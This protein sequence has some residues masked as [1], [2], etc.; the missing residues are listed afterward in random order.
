MTKQEYL[1]QIALHLKKLDEEEKQAVLDYYS[2]YLDDAEDMQQ[3]MQRL[4]QPKEVAYNAVANQAVQSMGASKNAGMRKG[5]NVLWVVAATLSPFVLI[6]AA[7]IIILFMALFLVVLVFVL[8]GL[9]VLGAGIYSFTKDFLSGVFF[10]G[11]GSAFMGLGLLILNAVWRLGGR[12]M[13]WMAVRL[14][15]RKNKGVAA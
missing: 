5:A 9:V 13:G 8:G 15:R 4:G 3:A 12:L 7:T 11:A 6:A 10:V 2:E 14:H 1:Q